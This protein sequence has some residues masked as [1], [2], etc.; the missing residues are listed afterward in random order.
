MFH[1]KFNSIPE[2]HRGFIALALGVVLFFGA[3]G[4]LGFLQNIL[5]VIMVA[6]GL[7][8]L[9]WGLEHS[10]IWGSLRGHKK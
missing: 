2:Q 7:Y 9:F 5:N 3:L 6:V 10:N 8:L 1:K 4:K